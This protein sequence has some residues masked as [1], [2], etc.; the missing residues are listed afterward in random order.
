MISDRRKALIEKYRAGSLERIGRVSLALASAEHEAIPAAKLQ[1]LKREV[2]TLKGESTMLGFQA[3]AEIA[4][5]AENAIE[6]NIALATVVDALDVVARYLR[7]DL[8]DEGEASLAMTRDLLRSSAGVEVPDGESRE[9]PAATFE[10]RSPDEPPQERWVRVSAERVDAVCEQVTDFDSTF[11]ALYFRLREAA[12]TGDGKLRAL[13]SDFERCQASLDEI[14]SAAWALRLVPIEPVLVDLVA[15]AREIATSQGKRVRMDARGGDVQIERTVLDVLAEPLLHLVRNAI[16]H[17]IE[18]PEERGAKGDAR[19]VVSGET[20]GGSVLIA[21]SDDGRGIDPDRVRKAV[22]ERGMLSDTTLGAMSDVEIVDLVFWHGLS[23]RADVT[24]LSG[25][26]VGLDVVRAT[27]EALGGTASVSS[28]VGKGTTFHLRVPAAITK[29]RTLVVESR[30]ALFGFPSRSVAALV[31]LS[32]HEVSAIAGGQ[33]LRIGDVAIPL[34]S[35]G[36]FLGEPGAHEPWAVVL[37]G[38]HQKWAFSIAKPLGDFPLLRRPI[39]RL[40]PT[41]SASATLADGRLVMIL[42][43]AALVRRAR[44]GTEAHVATGQSR[45]LRVLVIDDSAVV[46]DL[47]E[48]ILRQSGFDVQVADGGDEALSILARDR[49]DVVTLD[50]D[51]PGMTGFEV[52]GHIRARHGDLPVVMLTLRASSEDKARATA[53]GADAYVVKTQFQEGSLLEAI[54][55]VAKVVP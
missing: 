39:D 45:A 17:G 29:E 48:E 52:L 41:M 50:V 32:D 53:L 23:T 10:P 42:S 22:L 44:H 5:A 2:H 27:V 15:H 1:E 8:G 46:R 54:R 21:V 43:V 4:H 12:R 38:D 35:L 26:G 51:M 28:V 31:R 20:V 9:T 25:R 49:P 18:L 55:R 30:G 7:G 14:T 33:A 19:L 36:A 11:R 16:D 24:D 6:K 37:D 40:L 3:V 47:M 13:S 34:R